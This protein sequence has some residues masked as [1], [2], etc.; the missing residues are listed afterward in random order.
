MEDRDRL[1]KEKKLKK[2][3]ILLVIAIIFTALML[4]FPSLVSS[5]TPEGANVTAISTSTRTPS[6]ATSITAVAGNVTELI[7]SGTSVTQM[8]QGYYG[9]VTGIITLEDSIGNVFYNWSVASPEGE[10][11][12]TRNSTIDWTL[13][14][15]YNISAAK[16]PAGSSPNFQSDYYLNL[17][18]LEETELGAKIDDVDG[19]DETFAQAFTGEFYIGSTQISSTSGCSRVNTFVNNESQAANFTEV[20]LIQDDGSTDWYYNGCTDPCGSDSQDNSIEDIIWT[21]IIQESGSVGFNSE[22]WDFQML[23]A[24]NGHNGDTTTTE[25]YFYIEIS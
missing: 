17:S 9:N 23:V 1:D 5:L 16:M 7:I 19:I 8:W 14:E 12:A 15:C 6:N 21:T 13:V 24:E 18:E 2:N 4:L 25:Y 22:V 3:S 10:I 11:F 20:I